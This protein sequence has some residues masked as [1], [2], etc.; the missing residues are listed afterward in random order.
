M[1]RRGVK[2]LY[3]NFHNDTFGHNIDSGSL[4]LVFSTTL[5]R[6]FGVPSR[7]YLQHGDVVRRQEAVRPP[8][9]VDQP[10]RE[11]VVCHLL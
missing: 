7:A 11:I 2:L 3:A 8:E 5:K 4:S 9:Y 6:A 1:K 10:F